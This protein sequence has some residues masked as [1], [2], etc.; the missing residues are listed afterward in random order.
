MCR[1]YSTSCGCSRS[2]GV[3]YVSDSTSIRHTDKYNT[4]APYLSRLFEIWVNALKFNWCS[5]SW[6]TAHFLRWVISLDWSGKEKAKNNELTKESSCQDARFENVKKLIIFFVD[7]SS[8]CRKEIA[9]FTF[10]YL[11]FSTFCFSAHRSQEVQIK[12]EQIVFSILTTNV[13]E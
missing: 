4:Q 5:F 7:L 10:L 1:C 12:R 9:H 8:S 13:R 3:V 6:I 2:G 11:L